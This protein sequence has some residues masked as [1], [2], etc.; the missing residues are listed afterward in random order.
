MGGVSILSDE[1]APVC[2][3]CGYSL[4]GAP[5]LKVV[6]EESWFRCPECGLEGPMHPKRLPLAVRWTGWSLLACVVFIGLFISMTL[7]AM[8]IGHTGADPFRIEIANSDL[9][10]YNHGGIGAD[11]DLTRWTPVVEADLFHASGGWPAVFGLTT[12]GFLLVVALIWVCPSMI[13]ARF[14]RAGRSWFAMAPLIPAV[15]LA[16]SAGFAECAG[17]SASSSVRGYASTLATCHVGTIVSMIAG[18]VQGLA[19]VLG[20]LLGRRWHSTAMQNRNAL[21]RSS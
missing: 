14:S 19:V 13:A 11:V 12:L 20:M 1:S 5:V 10:I 18:L 15:L 6:N 8:W 21:Q 4:T 16:T 2:T 3:A 7:T 17:S 9:V